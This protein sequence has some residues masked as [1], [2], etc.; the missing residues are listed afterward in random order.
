MEVLNIKAINVIIL[1]GTCCNPSLAS[2]DEKIQTQI[3]E[4][5]KK[6]EIQVNIS[7]ITISAAAFGG[8]AGVSRGVDTFIRSLISDKGMSILPVVLFDGKVAFYGGLASVTLIEEKL[9][10]CICE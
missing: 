10:G 7:I 5:A 2:V 3:K 1:S 6:G 8:I 4:I 9:K